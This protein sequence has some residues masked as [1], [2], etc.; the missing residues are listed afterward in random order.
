MPMETLTDVLKEFKDKFPPANTFSK[1]VA[2]FTTEHIFNSINSFHPGLI[3]M[4]EDIVDELK[5]LGYS[6]EM[7]VV[8]NV[9]VF[10]W[11]T[12]DHYDLVKE[13]APTALETD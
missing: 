9:P 8:G 3:F 4:K 6:Y 11:K 2:L 7:G 13:V 1:K 12:D 5:K 10:R